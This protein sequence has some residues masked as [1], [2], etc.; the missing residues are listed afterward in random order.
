MSCST[1]AGL[2]GVTIWRHTDLRMAQF[3]FCFC[4]ATLLPECGG[5]VVRLQS[6]PP[7]PYRSQILLILNYLWQT[8]AMYR[9][10]AAAQRSHGTAA[11]FCFLLPHFWFLGGSDCSQSLECSWWTSDS[12]LQYFPPPGIRSWT[13]V[14]ELHILDCSPTPPPQYKLSPHPQTVSY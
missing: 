12:W 11:F 3:C 7:E 13:A 9:N 4:S 2:L 14:G 5:G 8:H 1:L 10:S 6:L